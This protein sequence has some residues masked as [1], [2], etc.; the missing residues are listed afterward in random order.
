MLVNYLVRWKMLRVYRTSLNFH[1][2]LSLCKILVV[3]SWNTYIDSDKNRHL[4]FVSGKYKIRKAAVRKRWFYRE[5]IEKE[6]HIFVPFA[7]ETLGP[8]CND[9][10]K[11]ITEIAKKVEDVTGEQRSREFL[12]QRVSFAVQRHNAGC[13]MGTFPDGKAL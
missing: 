13:V 7:I 1:T 2:K 4:T 12:I 11:F 8:I 6:N 10:L 3:A 5:I 9:G